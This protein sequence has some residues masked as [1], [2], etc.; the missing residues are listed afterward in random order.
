MK[1][2]IID[3][4]PVIAPNQ[5]ALAREVL[6]YLRRGWHRDGETQTVRPLHDLSTV[7]YMQQVVLTDEPNETFRSLRSRPGA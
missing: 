4:M 7:V 5:H 3:R 6:K 1:P 2:K